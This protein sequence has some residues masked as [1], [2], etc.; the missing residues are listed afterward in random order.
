MFEVVRQLVPV[1]LVVPNKIGEDVPSFPFD[2]PTTGSIE[3]KPA[4]MGAVNP[5]V[6]TTPQPT[7]DSM[8]EVHAIAEAM[9]KRQVVDCHSVAGTP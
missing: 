1:P 5:N 7:T 9:R 6:V 3:K 8:G 2:M 4:F